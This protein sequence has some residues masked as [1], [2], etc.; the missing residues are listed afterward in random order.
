MVT[1][2]HR[3]SIGQETASH[4]GITL[5][6]AHITP[7]K[8]YLLIAA[9]QCFCRTAPPDCAKH[10]TVGRLDDDDDARFRDIAKIRARALVIFDPSSLLTISVFCCTGWSLFLVYDVATP[11]LLNAFM[12]GRPGRQLT[13]PGLTIKLRD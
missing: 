4:A 5:D 7:K 13:L 9:P 3:T 10:D 1:A 2:Y 11:K 6:R 8:Y 12:L